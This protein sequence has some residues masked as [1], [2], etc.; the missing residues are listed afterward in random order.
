MTSTSQSR[1]R[2]GRTSEAQKLRTDLFGA[3][4]SCRVGVHLWPD[5]YEALLQQAAAEGITP[6]GMAHRIIRQQFNL[7]PIP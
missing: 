1:K 5:A 3:N 7:P 2:L 4:T 6:S